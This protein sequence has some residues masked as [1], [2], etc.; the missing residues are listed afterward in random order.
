LLGHITRLFFLHKIFSIPEQHAAH[1]AFAELI[2][3]M[4]LHGTIHL[5]SQLAQG[6]G[7]EIKGMVTICFVCKD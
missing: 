3:S 6:I 2:Q 5:L 7:S 4:K 1:S